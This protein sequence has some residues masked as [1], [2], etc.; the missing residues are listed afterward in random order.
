VRTLPSFL[1][2]DNTELKDGAIDAI[3]G[4]DDEDWLLVDVDQDETA[5]ADVLGDIVT[6]LGV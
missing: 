1:G 4:G 3:F 6:E 2:T 5:N